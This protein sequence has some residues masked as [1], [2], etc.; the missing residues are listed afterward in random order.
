MYIYIYILQINFHIRDHTYLFR[1]IMS[2][3]EKLAQI[4]LYTN[5]FL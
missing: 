3:I 1:E 5:M 4:Y 2:V